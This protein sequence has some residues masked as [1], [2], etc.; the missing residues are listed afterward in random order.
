MPSVLGRNE[1]EA[2]RDDRGD[3]ARLE[4]EHIVLEYGEDIMHRALHLRFAGVVR[5]FR[6]F[7]AELFSLH[8]RPVRFAQV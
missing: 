4:R 3:H 6:G 2:D 1:D 7:Q 5:A 8:R